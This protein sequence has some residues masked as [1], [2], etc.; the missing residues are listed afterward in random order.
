[1]WGKLHRIAWNA[2][3]KLYKILPTWLKLEIVVN[4]SFAMLGRLLNKVLPKGNVHLFHLGNSL[5]GTGTF[6]NLT[7]N[8]KLITCP[9]CQK[10]AD[11]HYIQHVDPDK[12]AEIPCFVYKPFMI[13][14]NEFKA[15]RDKR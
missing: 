9:K 10:I 8:E 7:T 14:R 13:M 6:R 12:L 3:L 2:D 1:M 15:P 4:R 11:D 5:C